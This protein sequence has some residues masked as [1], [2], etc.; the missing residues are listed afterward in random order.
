LGQVPTEKS[1]RGFAV[2]ASGRFLIAAGQESH[3][4]ALHP[5]DP[6]TGIPGAH[7]R[8]PAGKNPN[9]IEIVELP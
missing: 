9:W 1:P 7:T 4:V 5:I 6:A 3:H 2:D 8:V